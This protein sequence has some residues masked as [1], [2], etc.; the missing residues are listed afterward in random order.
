MDTDAILSGLARLDA[1]VRFAKDR[2]DYLCALVINGAEYLGVS[3][4]SAKDDPYTEALRC[5][6][7]DFLDRL[8]S[9]MDA[10]PDPVSRATL[11]DESRTELLHELASDGAEASVA[12][13]VSFSE[14]K[15]SKAFDSALG[16]YLK[17]T[18]YWDR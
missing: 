3:P 13:F 8:A 6:V 4:R 7:K 14:Y 12:W 18:G 16:N 5:A 1:P 17:Q 2:G 9:A 11:D 10:F 15:P